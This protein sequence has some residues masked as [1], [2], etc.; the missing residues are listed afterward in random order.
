MAVEHLNEG[1]RIANYRVESRKWITWSIQGGRSSVKSSDTRGSLVRLWTF[2]R[3]VDDVVIR[4]AGVS[5]AAKTCWRHNASN[6]FRP[7]VSDDHWV[8][9]PREKA[10]THDAGQLD[11]L[12]VQRHAVEDN[13]RGRSCVVRAVLG[14]LVVWSWSLPLHSA[15]SVDFKALDITGYSPTVVLRATTRQSCTAGLMSVKVQVSSRFFPT[16]E[17]AIDN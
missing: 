1:F 7:S 14:L 13:S 4:G 8:Q 10:S 15:A 3:H 11:S 5:R 16:E 9:A 2:G 17:T 6:S 12:C